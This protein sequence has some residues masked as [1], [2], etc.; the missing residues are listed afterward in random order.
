M[1]KLVYVYLGRIKTSPWSK[2]INKCAQIS[3]YL[4]R[5]KKTSPWSKVNKRA[6][7]SICTYISEEQKLARGRGQKTNKS[8]E[9]S[10]YIDKKKQSRGQKINKSAKLCIHLERKNEP[11]VKR[12]KQMC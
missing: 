2:D 5:R 11:R 10:T 4:G 7:I 8:A 9:I 6:K 1:L 12:Y 3:S